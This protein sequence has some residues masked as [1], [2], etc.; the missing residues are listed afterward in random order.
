MDQISTLSISQQHLIVQ[1]PQMQPNLKRLFEINN[2]R[3]PTIA[4]R[5][6]ALLERRA[7]TLISSS[8]KHPP[9]L[10]ANSEDTQPHQSYKIPIRPPKLDTSKIAFLGSQKSPSPLSATSQDRAKAI[11]DLVRNLHRASY[12]PTIFKPWLNE[13]DGNTVRKEL[14]STFCRLEEREKRRMELLS[15]GVAQQIE[16]RG[17]NRYQDILPFDSTRV[18][19]ATPGA[20]YIN[21]SYITSETK[22][23]IATQGPLTKTCTDFW[24]MVWDTNSSVIVLLTREEENGRGKCSRYWPEHVGDSKRFH[25]GGGEDI[26]CLM[27]EYVDEV[28]VMS[29]STVIRELLLTISYPFTRRNRSSNPDSTSKLIRMVHYLPWGD[30]TPSDPRS[31]VSLVEIV[32]EVGR[33]A[34]GGVIVG[35]SAGVGRTG[36]FITISAVL[37][38]LLRPRIAV[39]TALLD[40]TQGQGSNPFGK[41]T[42]QEDIGPEFDMIASTLDGFRQ[43]RPGFVQTFAQFQTIY[44]CVLIKLGDLLEEGVPVTW[45]VL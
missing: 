42:K 35:C 22:K 44:E 17:L 13:I 36:T 18:I 10:R 14:R 28:V 45:D 6:A 27:V 19:L 2:C 30:H 24:H 39:T 32:E 33:Q 43:Q 37:S 12:L 23:Y 16:N 11:M 34:S 3:K 15:R 29:E 38:Q 4:D 25:R 20:D 26:I 8:S 1:N 31:L 40:Q 7:T 5:R 9:L 41:W 21:A